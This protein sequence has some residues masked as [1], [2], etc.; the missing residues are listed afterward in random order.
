LILLINLDFS[1]AKAS[2]FTLLRYSYLWILYIQ[3]S[4][5]NEARTINIDTIKP[6]AFVEYI[7]EK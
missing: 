6:K 5:L 2:L 7:P 4:H 3:H 1:Y